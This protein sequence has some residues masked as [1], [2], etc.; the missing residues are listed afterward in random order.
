V[1]MLYGML[2]SSTD[3]WKK[4]R[5]WIIRFLSDGLVNTEDWRVFQRRH[6]WDLLASLFQSSES[7]HPL[8]NGILEVLANLTCNSQAATSLVLRSALLTW[9]EMQI[10]LS[11]EEGVA[12]IKIL[13]NVLTVT[14]SS[15]LEVSTNGD[16]RSV[17]FRCLLLLLD[18]S[19][20]SQNSALL[21]LASPVILRLTLLPGRSISGL[22]MLLQHCVSAL[23]RLETSLDLTQR[24][25]AS[26]PQKLRRAPPHRAPGL[27]DLNDADDD[28]LA[29]GETVEHLWRVSMALEVKSAAWDFL[30]SRLLIWRSV[31]GEEDTVVGEW[32]R[33]Q[34]ILNLAT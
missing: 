30:T 12:W 5:G 28:V 32:A 21:F 25:D 34:V 4:E 13:E 1:P 33:T 3:D 24:G 29:W 23:E 7:D 8:R 26:T 16:W 27:H 6:T 20:P 10:T 19:K 17:I 31:R 15:K 18:H 14:D 9:I 22:P 2:Y 11:R